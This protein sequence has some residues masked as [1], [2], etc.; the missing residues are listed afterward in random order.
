MEMADDQRQ[1]VLVLTHN[2]PRYANDISGIGFQPLYQSLARNIALHFVVPHDAGLKDTETVNGLDVHRFRYAAD[3][4]E[5]LAYRGDMHKRV[6]TSPFLAL[7]FIKAYLKK[8]V[9]VAA[10]VRPT[11]IWAHWWIPGGIIAR[12]LSA[13]TGI[14]FVV[15]CHGTDIHLLK[16]FPLMKPVARRV[17]TEA[18]TINVVSTFLKQ[19]LIEALGNVYADK[20][21]VAPLIVDTSHIHFDPDH[22]RRPG[23]IISASRYT[24]QKH[25]DI[26]LQ[27]VAKLK[28]DGVHY[29]LDLH[30]S[31][32]EEK[33]LKSLAGQLGLGD[34]VHFL[35][36]VPQAELA[37]RYRD[38]EIICL[39]S[40]REGFGLMLVEAMMCGCAAVG[41]KSGGITDIITQDG[42]DG[43]LVPP[44]NV[45]ALT[46][47]LKRLLTNRELLQ[48]I[49]TK[50]R[51]S[52]EERFSA[53]AITA[54]F[55]GM[56]SN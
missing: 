56:L 15:T 35:P 7:G 49:A 16:K 46:E 2:F 10:A 19:S 20:I 12:K 40:E 33:A 17:F 8:A 27:A 32:P 34:S 25:L 43:L 3:D 52:I 48:T 39:V 18:K 21:K 5:T 47:A 41:A 28:G 1:S 30:G 6:L 50:G 55:M 29:S 42:V 36:P 38:S 13:Q 26:L 31:G 23:S 54:E 37:E 9:E 45:E 24:K 51:T 4:R 53:A 14:P 11:T 44:R 22:Q